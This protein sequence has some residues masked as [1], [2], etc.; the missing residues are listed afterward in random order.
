MKD[1]LGIIYAAEEDVDLRELQ[2][3]VLWRPY[4]LEVGTEPLTFHFPIW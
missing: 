2:G 4:L 1:T 3:N